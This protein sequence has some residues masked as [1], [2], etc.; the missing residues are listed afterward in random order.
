MVEF[1]LEEFAREFRGIPLRSPSVDGAFYIDCFGGRTRRTYFSKE[2]DMGSLD[3]MNLFAP[4]AFEEYFEWV[5]LAESV[6]AAGESFTMVELGAGYARWVVLGAVLARALG[7]RIERLCAYEAEP[8]HYLWT[9]QQFSDNGLD[10]AEY[11]VVQAAVGP[12]EGVCKFYTGCADEWWGQS[13]APESEPMMSTIRRFLNRLLRRAGDMHP[14]QEVPVVTLDSILSDYE[15]V[16]FI[17]SDIQGSELDV[18]EVSMDELDRKVRKVLIATHPPSVVGTGGKDVELG[19]RRLFAGK[20]WTCIRDIPA[21]SKGYPV[22][23]YTTD[24]D[25]G[26]QTW[27]NPRYPGRRSP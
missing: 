20:G 24:I 15:Y 18:I 21:L 10:P 7:K 11:Q 8:D 6:L 9:R 14:V 17:H 4:S 1:M 12:R 25:D 22:G 5:D 27:L 13:I 2:R 16:D 19:I 26:T 3:L 23:K